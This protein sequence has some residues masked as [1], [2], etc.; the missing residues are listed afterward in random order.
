MNAENLARNCPF[1]GDNQTQSQAQLPCGICLRDLGDTDEIYRLACCGHAYDKRCII[2]QLRSSVVPLKC[3]TENCEEPVVWKDFQNLLSQSERKKLLLSSL[4]AYVRCNPD[5]VKYCPTPDCGMVYRVS[6]DGRS[7]K[8]GACSADICTSCHTQSHR[9][10]TCAMF[11]SGRNVEEDFK[12]WMR[13]DPSNRKN[14]PQCNAP[15]EK[16]QGCNHMECS[17]CKAHMC[18]LCLGVFRT[19]HEVYDHQSHCPNK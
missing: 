4:D 5:S 11:K 19:G 14:C 16:N 18:W 1:Q 7:H 12:E 2:Q 15:I 9:G 17:Q 10:L 13:K 8:C 6:T 3:V